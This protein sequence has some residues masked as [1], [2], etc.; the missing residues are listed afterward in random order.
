M[1][2]TEQKE[3]SF[4]ENIITEIV[5]NMCG[6]SFNVE[7]GWGWPGGI[8]KLSFNYGSGYDLFDSEFDDIDICDKCCTEIFDKMKIDPRPKV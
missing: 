6:K 1:R 4:V 2:I 5:C 3:V 7:K 8:V